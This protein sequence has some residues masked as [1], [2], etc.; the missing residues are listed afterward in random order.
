M[1]MLAC[2]N[3]SVQPQ[4]THPCFLH[5]ECVKNQGLVFIMVSILVKHAKWVYI[6]YCHNVCFNFPWSFYFE[7]YFYLRVLILVDWFWIKESLESLFHLPIL[8]LFSWKE[9][10]TVR[11]FLWVI[12]LLLREIDSLVV[13]TTASTLSSLIP[14][15]LVQYL[16]DAAYFSVVDQPVTNVTP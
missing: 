6:F 14:Y 9:L 15:E 5:A 11:D 10:A 4:P 2:R 8:F 13:R 7:L 3:Q 12:L 16:C 1:K